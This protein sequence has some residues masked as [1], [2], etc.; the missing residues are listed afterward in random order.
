MSLLE[1]FVVFAL[2]G[3]FLEPPGVAGGFFV[4]LVVVVVGV[5]LFGVGDF[6]MLV[7]GDLTST[8]LGLSAGEFKAAEVEVEVDGDKDEEGVDKAGKGNGD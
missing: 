7:M 4:E 3:S 6:V 5:V 1:D 2:A 8:V